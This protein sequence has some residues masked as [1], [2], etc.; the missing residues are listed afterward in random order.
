MKPVYT[1]KATVTNVVDGDTIDCS[2]DL[3][4]NTKTDIRFRIFTQDDEYFDTPETW[5]PKTE[6]EKNHGTKASLRAEELLAGQEVVLRSIRKGKYRYLAE[7]F[8]SDGRNY[9]NIMI[10]EGYQKRNDYK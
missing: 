9:A 3:G 1:Y 10:E 6:S 7:V 4:F 8:L 2:V 5:R